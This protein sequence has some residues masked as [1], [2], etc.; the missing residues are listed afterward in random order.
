M[1]VFPQFWTLSSHLTPLWRGEGWR[2][3][4]GNQGLHQCIAEGCD[5][6]GKGRVW[7]GTAGLTILTSTSAQWGISGV[8]LLFFMD[9]GRAWKQ[10]VTPPMAEWLQLAFA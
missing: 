10:S 9:N 4:A 7:G 5:P 2:R 8:K 1:C 3:P 6:R